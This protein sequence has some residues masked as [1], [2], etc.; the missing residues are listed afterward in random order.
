MVLADTT[1]RYPK[2]AAPV[3]EERIKLAQTK[4]MEAVVD[5]TLA[6]WFTEPYRK[7]HPDVVARIGD[8]IRTTPVAGFVGCCQAIPTID[9]TQRLKE[10]SGGIRRCSARLSRPRVKIK[11]ALLRGR[12]HG[13]PACCASAA[14]DQLFLPGRLTTGFFFGS[15]GR[16]LP[17]EP[18]KILP[19]IVRLSPLPIAFRP[20]LVDI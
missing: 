8:S 20:D 1:S 11:A 15:C 9:V 14:R 2:E 5:G 12:L 7:S 16:V 19:R 18:L 13:R 6:R 17:Y 3:W 10:T 4:G